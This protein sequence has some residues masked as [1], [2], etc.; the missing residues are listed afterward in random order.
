[1]A[2][3]VLAFFGG[4]G[5]ILYGACWLLVPYEATGEAP[6]TLDERSSAGQAYHDAVRRLTGEQVTWLDAAT[7]GPRTTEDVSVST[8]VLGDGDTGDADDC[9]AVWEIVPS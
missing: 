4:A 8:S 2:F 5:L 1:M 6:V 7:L 9:T 3:G